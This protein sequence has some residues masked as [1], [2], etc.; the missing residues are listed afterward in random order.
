MKLSSSR[1]VLQIATAT[2]FISAFACT[3]WLITDYIFLDGYKEIF[4][5]L[6]ALCAFFALVS[7]A[8]ILNLLRGNPSVADSSAFVFSRRARK[9]I[10]LV[11]LVS[12]LPILV[13]SGALIF[14]DLQSMGPAEVSIFGTSYL[15]DQIDSYDVPPWPPLHNLDKVI[16]GGPDID[17][18]PFMDDMERRIKFNWIS[19]HPPKSRL[20]RQ[21]TVRFRWQLNGTVS[22][23]TIKRTSGL[24]SMD[25]SALKA[26]KTAKLHPLP[27]GADG[28]VDCLLEFDYFV[29]PSHPATG[30]QNHSF[31]FSP[32]SDVRAAE[33][34][35]EEDLMDGYINIVRCG[36]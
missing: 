14:G 35:C 26:V 12:P 36:D 24:Q 29:M 10:R 2:Y 19:R 34:D 6:F 16:C 1:F 8:C 3:S 13:Y 9:I 18:G 20:S 15:L 22:G 4:I 7:I 28:C 11:A 17:F 27:K 30:P 23:A 31:D 25:E 21:V 5:P 32:H 33:N